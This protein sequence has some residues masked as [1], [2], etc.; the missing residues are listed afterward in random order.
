MCF[1]RISEIA[2]IISL[3]SIYGLD[4]IT[5]NSI[6]CALRTGSLTKTKYV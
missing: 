2:A 5:E 6:Y 4:F 3:Y 1:I